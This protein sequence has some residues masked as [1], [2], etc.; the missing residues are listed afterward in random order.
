MYTYFLLKCVIIFYK[1][2]TGD[3]I[4]ANSEPSY[5]KIYV[6]E[7]WIYICF[8]TCST[9]LTL[10]TYLICLVCLMYLIVQ[11]FII[12]VTKKSHQ[13]SSYTLKSLRLIYRLF[14]PVYISEPFYINL[15]RQSPRSLSLFTGPQN[16][17]IVSLTSTL[18][19]ECMDYVI[20]FLLRSVERGRVFPNII[21]SQLTY[22]WI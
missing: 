18:V 16:Y 11:P 5:E 17:I 1:L 22:L 20:D 19:Y 8:V 21:I 10:Q 2:Y 9:T 3:N 12:L 13:N 4:R 15:N 7:T 14:G 6:G